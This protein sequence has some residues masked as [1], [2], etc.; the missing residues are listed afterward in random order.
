MRP[1]H[2]DFVAALAANDAKPRMIAAIPSDLGN[3]LDM[4]S[5]YD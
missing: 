4:G 5:S 3:S 1:G 2:R